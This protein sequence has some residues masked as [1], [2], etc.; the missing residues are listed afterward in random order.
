MFPNFGE[1]VLKAAARANRPSGS[2]G[3][4]KF[5]AVLL[6]GMAGGLWVL[7]LPYP[8][9]RWPV[10]RVA[11]ILLL[12]SFVSMDYHYRRAIALVEQADQLVNQSTGPADLT[13]GEGKVKEAQHHLD[14]LPVWFLGYF[15]QHRF[16][17]GWQFTFDEFQT[18]RAN[19]ARMDA[20][21]FQEKQAQ[22]LL[23]Q[24]EQALNT[25]KQQYQQAKTVADRSVAIAAWLA[26][27]DT[28]QQIPPETLAGRAAQTKLTAYTRDYQQVEGLAVGNARSGTLIE[29]A[30]EFAKAATQSSQNSPHTASEWNKALDLWQK[31]IERL[32]EIPLEDPGYASA[33]KLL[34]TYQT[35][36]GTVQTHLQAEQEAMEALM[37]AQGKIQN[38]VASGSSTD[39]NQMIGQLQGIMDQ[40]EAVQPETT[41]YPKAHTLLKSAQQKQEQL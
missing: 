14:A 41:A 11:P 32:E 26:A 36:L 3:K 20:K 9:I 28:L 19:V 37:Q 22:T 33:Q 34:A 4:I 38:L 16:W 7:N 39:Q 6:G 2:S 18:A 8:R 17:G 29:A 5:A 21:L 23:R 10:A 1:K 27:L 15:P 13:L 30:Q 12:P 31:A 24:G 40:L 25:A 35:N